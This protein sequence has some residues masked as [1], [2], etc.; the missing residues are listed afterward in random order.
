MELR[1]R[2]APSSWEEFIGGK[3]GMVFRGVKFEGTG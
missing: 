3:I 1:T 2:D